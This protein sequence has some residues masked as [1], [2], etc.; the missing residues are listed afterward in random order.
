MI[1]PRNPNS[2]I[3]ETREALEFLVAM[4]NAT[5]QAAQDGF[6]VSDATFFHSGPS[7]SPG[8]L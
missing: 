2:T 4:A 5:D 3:K 1:K 7:E 6:T 8:S